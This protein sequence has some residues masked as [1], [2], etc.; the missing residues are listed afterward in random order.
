MKIYASKPNKYIRS[1][2][3][4]AKLEALYNRVVGILAEAPKYSDYIA[5]II[6]SGHEIIA[7][8]YEPDYLQN[9]RGDIGPLWGINVFFKVTGL[10]FDYP[11][12]QLTEDFVLEEKKTVE[13]GYGYREYVIDKITGMLKYN[14]ITFDDE[15]D[16][17]IQ[18]WTE[19]NDELQDWVNAENS[20]YD[21]NIE[22][23]D[24]TIQKLNKLMDG[25]PDY[26]NM[27][28]CDIKLMISPISGNGFSYLDGEPARL[29]IGVLYTR[30]TVDDVLN[31]LGKELDTAI[32]RSMK[33]EGDVTMSMSQLED[34]FEERLALVES[35]LRKKFKD[36][37]ISIKDAKIV[38]WYPGAWEVSYAYDYTIVVNGD[39]YVKE[40]GKT[41]W[42]KMT[43]RELIN[44]FVNI[45]S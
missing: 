16:D 24:E 31:T 21:Y 7:T 8:G 23:T 39:E 18:Y 40:M 6:N 41:R 15:L 19:L 5:S 17:K 32:T 20:K 44:Y 1:N 29:S 14:Y 11:Q 9:L 34:E 13:P 3:Q 42:D 2:K 28:T 33:S 30:D 36:W 22:L 45:I 12:S 43:D 38:K 35:S 27:D 4:D 10:A 37:D 25:A 26:G